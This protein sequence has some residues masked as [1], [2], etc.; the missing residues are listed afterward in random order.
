MRSLGK[1][2]YGWKFFICAI[3]TLVCVRTTI[4]Q[5]ITIS[6]Q[7]F[8]KDNKTPVTLANVII[9]NTFAGTVT[10]DEGKF[11]IQTSAANDTLLVGFIGYKTDTVLLTDEEHQYYRLILQSE[12][13]D[14]NEVV[15]KPRE[16]PAKVLMK[17]VIA[18]KKENDQQNIVAYKT[19]GYTKI[20]LD[21]GNLSE[22]QNDTTRK[23]GPF[24]ILRDHI[25]STSDVT[26]FLPF[27]FTETV[28]DFYYRKNP[29][30]RKEVIVASRTS[31]INNASATQILGNYYEQFDI[32]DNYWF[33]LS[34]N[35]VTPTTDAWNF[36]YHVDLVDS[37]MIENDW[38]YKV[39]FTPRQQQENVFNGYMWIA[40]SSYAVK[41]VYM[42]LDSSVNI[43][44]YKRAVFYMEFDHF[45]DSVWVMS[46]DNLIVEFMP[47]KNSA[48]VI[49]RKTTVYTDYNFDHNIFEEVA[50]YKDD[51]VYNDTVINNDEQFWATVRPDSLS[52]NETGVYDLVDSLKHIKSFMTLVD[53]YNTLMYG[54]WNLGYVRIGP[55]AN[56][57]SSNDVEGF[58]LRIGGKTGDLISKRFSIGGYG[59]YGFKDN[60]FKYGGEFNI[61]LSKK[62]YQQFKFNYDNDLDISNNDNV[63][64][65]EDNLL[66]GFYRRRDTPQKIVDRV[67]FQG[68]YQKDWIWGLS[69][70]LTLSSVHL[71]PMFDIYYF[72]NNDSLVSS[73]DNS[74]LKIGL[75]FAY[76]EKFLFD[77]YRRYSLGTKYPKLEMYYR[78]GLK[79]FAGGHFNYNA[80]EI[81]IW[82]FFTLGSIGGTSYTIKAGKIFGTLPTL[83]LETPPGNET[84]FMNHNTFNLMNEYEFVND[85]YAELFLTHSFY[86]FFLNK[87]PYVNK[88]KLREIATFKMAYGTMTE[89]N[90]EANAYLKNT[91]PFYIGNG[92][93]GNKPYM[94]A[95]VGIENIFKLI[96]VDAIWR[97]TYRNNPLAPNFGVRLGVNLDI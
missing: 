24:E 29:K 65:G 33:L 95:G 47:T 45:R 68:Y 20:E 40:D 58:R 50:Q 1:Y 91:E 26:N 3:L 31:G 54:Y 73:I 14:L 89:A 81:D 43:N 10:D 19:R 4:A 11:E 64:F 53:V 7:V 6:G 12:D 57:V 39:R 83:L 37:A 84:Y 32:Y 23:M 28:S 48:S 17:K 66:S 22:P 80:F 97:L 56:M 74:E 77:N 38:C 5:T 35:F 67:R 96:R 44:Y 90:R 49:G 92:G 51:I 18:H 71:D 41:E 52:Q 61:V 63:T 36:F 78:T 72:N 15:I 27:F 94:E 8:E 60:E 75:R 86:G 62:P 2:Y 87:I 25:D 70:S 85:T 79:N 13:F 69:N 42:Q 16:D 55:F 9:K 46:R 88:L 82:D 30:T 34:K 59:A 93:T 21:F 76:R